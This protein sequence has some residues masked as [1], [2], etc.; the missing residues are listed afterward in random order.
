MSVLPGKKKKKI[1]I[2][3]SP[4]FIYRNYIPRSAS[5]IYV[6]C[7]GNCA[8]L[9]AEYFSRAADVT[10]NKI[11]TQISLLNIFRDNIVP[12][13]CAPSLRPSLL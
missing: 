3:S 12:V 13:G 5:T 9:L 2:P 1:A 8:V 11:E 6:H 7:R 10:L 4:K